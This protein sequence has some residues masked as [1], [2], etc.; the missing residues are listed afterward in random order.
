MTAVKALKYILFCRST[1]D[2]EIETPVKG[3]LGL[4][5]NSDSELSSPVK[6]L[7]MMHD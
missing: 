2:S 3:K 6:R 1:S 4:D 7:V 5:F